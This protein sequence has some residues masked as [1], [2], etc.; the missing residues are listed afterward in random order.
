M[1]SDGPRPPSKPFA[2]ILDRL[3]RFRPA[4][5][6][7]WELKKIPLAPGTPSFGAPCRSSSPVSHQ[8]P[9]RACRGRARLDRVLRSSRGCPA[10]AAVGARSGSPRARAAGA[11]SRGRH[12]R[13]AS[14]RRAGCCAAR[15]AAD[16]SGSSR[17]PVGAGTAS[18]IGTVLPSGHDRRGLLHAMQRP[19]RVPAPPRPVSGP[20]H[21]PPAES[22][23]NTVS[24]NGNPRAERMTLWLATA[25]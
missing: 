20:K 19:P 17:R 12:Q 24:P 5:S 3:R 21:I 6:G 18:I 11:C 15:Q 13:A 2:A 23:E 16:A 10:A 7:I 9:F 4:F 25:R 22:D 1:G 14:S 8:R